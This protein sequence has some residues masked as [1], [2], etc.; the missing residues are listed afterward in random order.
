MSAIIIALAVISAISGAI[1]IVQSF[2]TEVMQTIVGTGRGE[3]FWNYYSFSNIETMTIKMERGED[4]IRNYIVAKALA[5]AKSPAIQQHKQEITD[6][7][8]AL[9]DFQGY[10]FETAQKALN[11]VSYNNEDLT[12][13]MWIYTFT[14]LE[15]RG[16]EVLRY[17]GMRL[18]TKGIKLAK[19]W[20]LVNTVSSNM[21][22]QKNVIEHRY[23]PASLTITKIID[24]IAVAFA[25][26]ALGLVKV[27]SGFLDAMKSCVQQAKVSDLPQPMT[28]EQLEYAQRTYDA[29]V[30]RQKERDA[31][32]IEGIKEI[33]EAIGL[34]LEKMAPPEDLAHY[35]A[36]MAQDHANLLVIPDV[37]LYHL[38]QLAALEARLQ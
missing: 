28:K 20:M 10:E 13:F 25:P 7:M 9:A 4:F 2:K 18:E 37:I 26:V 24:A 14:P 35:R 31:L 16:K 8:I 38:K 15:I 34:Q 6:Y 30:A 19:D 36:L 17:E 33:G 22:K 5:Q 12:L 1:K 21:L 27:P 29:F 32:A 11:T 23:L 3:G